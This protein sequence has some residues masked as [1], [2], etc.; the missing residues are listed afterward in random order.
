[1]PAALQLEWFGPL[2]EARGKRIVPLKLDV[3]DKD[4][5]AAA[6]DAAVMRQR[7]RNTPL[8]RFPS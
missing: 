4:D 1:M 5:I 7:R 3:T 8:L 2:C 6:V